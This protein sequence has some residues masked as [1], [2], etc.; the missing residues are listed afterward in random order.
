ML[1]VAPRGNARSIQDFAWGADATADRI[2]ATSALDDYDTHDPHDYFGGYHRGFDLTTGK[3]TVSLE[4]K[5]GGESLA[6]HPRGKSTCR[7]NGLKMLIMY[8]RR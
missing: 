4:N 5:R 3:I 1:D 6:L 7:A 8:F 2:Y